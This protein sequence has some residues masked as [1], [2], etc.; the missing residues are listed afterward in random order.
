MLYSRTHLVTPI[1]KTSGKKGIQMIHNFRTAKSLKQAS[2][3]ISFIFFSLFFQLLPN[4]QTHFNT[5]G[6]YGKH[7]I[8]WNGLSTES[9][10]DIMAYLELA[11][12]QWC[13]ECSTV[14]EYCQVHEVV[15]NCVPQEQN[16]SLHSG[17]V[18]RSLLP[19]PWK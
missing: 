13:A 17:F 11:W 9:F 18:Q 16:N 14:S 10:E 6:T 2:L 15:E 8:L 1:E 7:K 12:Y 19:L 3:V 5:R 4:R